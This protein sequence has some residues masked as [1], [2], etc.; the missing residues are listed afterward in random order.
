MSPLRRPIKR[1]VN[2]S[3]LISSKGVHDMEV[4]RDKTNE[5]TRMV[6]N[7]LC[8]RTDTTHT[9]SIGI[10]SRD[11]QSIS[12]LHST[13]NSITQTF[14]NIKTRAAVRLLS[15]LCTSMSCTPLDDQ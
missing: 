15:K 3:H 13:S 2:G 4:N 14:N 7:E 6:H 12:T 11:N 9:K 8:T 5:T 10:A 1:T